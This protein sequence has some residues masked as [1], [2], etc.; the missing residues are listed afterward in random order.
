MGPMQNLC[1]PKAQTL[2]YPFS[3]RQ[4][5]LDWQALTCDSQASTC[6]SHCCHAHMVG[7]CHD[8]LDT[9]CWPGRRISRP[10]PSTVEEFAGYSLSR[11]RP[12]WYV[13]EYKRIVIYLTPCD[14]P[15][16]RQERRSAHGRSPL[17]KE[18]SQCLVCRFPTRVAHAHH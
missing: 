2:V 8:S 6:A 15:W 13:V 12:W 10:P 1:G 7:L 14:T 18:Y 16:H 9:R 17:N 11:F 4:K 3:T 5:S